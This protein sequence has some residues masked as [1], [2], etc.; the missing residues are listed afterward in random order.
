MP[1]ASS[2]RSFRPGWFDQSL[3]RFLADE[4]PTNVQGIHV[5]CDLGSSTATVLS[6]LTPV[7]ARDLPAILFDE[8]YNYPAYADHEFKAFLEWANR[9]GAVFEVVSKTAHQQVLIKIM[10]II[11]PSHHHPVLDL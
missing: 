5:D 6:L 9:V 10:K 8:F 4:P 1:K 11:K 3:P 2:N 7:I